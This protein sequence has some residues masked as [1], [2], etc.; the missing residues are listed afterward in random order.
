MTRLAGGSAHKSVTSDPPVALTQ[1]A[2]QRIGCLRNGDFLI[3]NVEPAA[4]SA[5]TGAVRSFQT[6]RSIQRR[7]G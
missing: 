5:R 3:E 4:Q 1:R 2:D 6:R 7:A